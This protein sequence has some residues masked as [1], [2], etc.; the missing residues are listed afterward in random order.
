MNA[1]YLVFRCI[2]LICG[3]NMVATENVMSDAAS[4]TAGWRTSLKVGSAEVS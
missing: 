1:S 4:A 3:A 2:P